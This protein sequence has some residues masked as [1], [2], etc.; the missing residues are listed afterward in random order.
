M[1]E[2]N[3]DQHQQ[4]LGNCNFKK[5]KLEILLWFILSLELKKKMRIWHLVDIPPTLVV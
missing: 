2:H 5:Q 3:L 4:N 1:T